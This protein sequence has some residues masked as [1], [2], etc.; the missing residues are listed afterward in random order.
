M[1][2][3]IS[4]RID[5]GSVVVHRIPNGGLELVFEVGVGARLVRRDLDHAGRFDDSSPHFVWS[6][7]WICVNP[8]WFVTTGLEYRDNKLFRCRESWIRSGS[9]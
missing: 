4:E 1:P 8:R 7:N 3:G 6:E 9:C 2:H 5:D